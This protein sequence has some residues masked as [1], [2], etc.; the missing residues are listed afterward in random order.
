MQYCVNPLENKL[1]NE[2]LYRSAR[3]FRMPQ[4]RD[5]INVFEAIK[6][7]KDSTAVEALSM[8]FYLSFP[9]ASPNSLNFLSDS[10]KKAIK[11]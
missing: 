2:T 7:L 9:E 11:N 1:Q 10:Y 6:K 8:M 4:S 5:L 3:L